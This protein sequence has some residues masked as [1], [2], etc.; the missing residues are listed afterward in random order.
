MAI[1]KEVH[2]YSDGLKL[3]ATLY[4]P[5]ETRAAGGKTWPV[6]LM[7]H[8]L[9]A[10]RK[11]FMPAF[12]E[13]F[14]RA[15]YISFIPDYR[16]FGESEGPKNRLIS[17]EREND[18]INAITYLGLQPEVDPDRIGLF[19]ISYGG[20]TAI[21]VAARDSRARCVVSVVTFGDGDRWMR[22]SRR[23]WEYFAL[24]DRLE[25][26]RRARVVKGESEYVDFAEILVPTPPEEKLYASAEL[27]ALRITFP[28]E[29]AEDIISYKPEKVV[30]EISP[31]PLLLIGGD[32]DYLVG[33]EESV[34][35]YE[36]A[37]EP[38]ELIM[39]PGMTH[40]DVYSAGFAPTMEAALRTFG[41]A[42]S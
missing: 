4:L 18:I 14:V 7:C 1:K 9:R 35:L 10:D 37:K 22:N 40:Y 3:A 38:K 36:L 24:R 41:L 5:D 21:G 34:R 30:H 23:L 25:K 13:E 19:G 16:G 31:R 15:G 26:D 29:T 32:Q 33:W 39:L 12:A 11:V 6:A 27:K 8:G 17:L 42:L 2:Y 20:A 28:L